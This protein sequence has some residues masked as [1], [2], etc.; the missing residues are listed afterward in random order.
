MSND[1]QH[2]TNRETEAQAQAQASEQADRARHKR[3]R[4]A[5]VARGEDPADHYTAEELAW[6]DAA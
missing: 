5:L 4:D 6:I 1:P 3:R 2:V